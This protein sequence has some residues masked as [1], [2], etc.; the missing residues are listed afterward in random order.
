[1]AAARFQAGQGRVRFD[2]RLVPPLFAA[3]AANALSGRAKFFSI[4]FAFIE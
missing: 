1:M 3:N 4:A 2:R